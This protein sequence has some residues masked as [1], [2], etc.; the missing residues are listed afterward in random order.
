MAAR[1]SILITYFVELPCVVVTVV[2][3]DL[4]PEDANV[5]SDSEVV[6]HEWALGAVLL[7]NHLSLEESAL[8][9]AR[10]FDFWLGQHDGLVLKVV[11]D[12]YFSDSV[13]LKSALNNTFLEVAVESQHL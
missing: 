10:V 8:R 9:G 2:D 4:S 7:Q 11:E 6:R 1:V 13:I 5:H 12:G 3:A